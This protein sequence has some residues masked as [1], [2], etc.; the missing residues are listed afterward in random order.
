MPAIPRTA[1]LL[2]TVWIAGCATRGGA[3]DDA[4][5]RRLELD[6]E[7]Y[8]V[9]DPSW[10]AVRDRWYDE[11]GP[12]RDLLVDLL[13]REMLVAS[14]GREW[15]RPQRDLLSLGSEVT[16][17]KLIGQMRRLRDP[18]ALDAVAD[19]LAGF[20]AVDE[21]LAALTAPPN[22][23]DGP[24]FRHYAM[25]A[26]VRS[27]G[28]RSLDYVSGQLTDSSNWELRAAAAEA[29]GKSR[30][31]DQPRAATL[32]QAGLV[33]SDTFVVRRALVALAD[34]E[35]SSAAPAVAEAY[36]RLRQAGDR[37]GANEAVR[38]LRRLTGVTVNGDDPE[39]WR[40]AAAR[41]ATARRP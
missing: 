31:S 29:L 20:A 15:K 7:L 22:L 11:G 17:P 3:L 16:V 33:D 12:A 13:T 23:D 10:P 28:S 27:G 5:Q 4:D 6:W 2:L 36:D 34:L 19:T 24:R 40:Q 14:M 18:A 32:L 30:I 25:Q 1:L 41:A 26:L 8:Q 35:Q 9:G 37:D 38:T 21:L 39:R